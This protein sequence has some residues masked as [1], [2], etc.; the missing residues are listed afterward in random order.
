MWGR[1]CRSPSGIVGCVDASWRRGSGAVDQAGATNACSPRPTVT[2]AVPHRASLSAIGPARRPSH[3]IVKCFRSVSTISRSM[4]CYY[5]QGN[6]L[7][8]ASCLS[9]GRRLSISRDVARVFS[10]LEMTLNHMLQRTGDQRCFTARWSGQKSGVVPL[11]PL[12]LGRL[13]VMLVHHH[14]RLSSSYPTADRCCRGKTRPS[15]ILPEGPEPGR[16]VYL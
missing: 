14:G 3:T 12:S 4:R 9:Y 11:P 1:W 8:I 15:R 13:A 6:C 7:R 10:S 16:V 5:S 2:S